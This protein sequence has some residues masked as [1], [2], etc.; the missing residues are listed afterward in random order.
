VTD[1]D[2]MRG[3]PSE[4]QRDEGSFFDDLPLEDDGMPSQDAMLE[5]L[6]AVMDPE[7]GINIVDLGLVYYLEKADGH[8]DVTMTLTSMGCPLTELI[9]QQVE[10]V[11][12]RLPGVEHAEVQFTFT[13]PW[14]TDMISD[15]AREELR[16]M[17]FML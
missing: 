17:G 6:K 1:A 7:I 9:Q 15:D 14:S 12:T 16:A 2:T 5:T 13:P 3:W 4:E 8:V 10:L 11:L